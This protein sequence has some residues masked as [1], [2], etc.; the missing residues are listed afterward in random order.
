M[1]DTGMSDD[2]MTTSG[3]TERD[4]NLD[5]GGEGPRD[6]GDEPTEEKDDKDAG[7]SQAGKDTGDR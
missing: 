6:T 5:K 7:G 2:D 3:P 4:D 1:S